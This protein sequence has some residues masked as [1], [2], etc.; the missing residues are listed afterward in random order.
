MGRN[1]AEGGAVRMIGRE[2]KERA[3]PV[4]RRLPG[5]RFARLVQRQRGQ[6]YQQRM[7]G[8]ALMRAEGWVVAHRVVGEGDEQLGQR[9][10]RGL[11]LGVA[12]ADQG[13]REEVQS[14]GVHESLSGRSVWQAFETETA[15]A[16][17]GATK[18]EREAAGLGD[19]V[20]GGGVFG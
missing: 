13:F 8:M 14:G 10:R 3:L 18:T 7:P 15:V 17:A 11:P 16:I 5:L 9:E 12:N 2:R 4:G 20:F 6:L 19:D 1:Q